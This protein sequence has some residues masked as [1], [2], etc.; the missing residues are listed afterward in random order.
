MTVYRALDNLIKEDRIHKSNQTKTFI[1]CNHSTSSNHNT[2]IAI[3]KKC[4]DTEELKSRFFKISL[5]E[6]M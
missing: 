6:T 2:A 3:C 5:K 1:L 4:G